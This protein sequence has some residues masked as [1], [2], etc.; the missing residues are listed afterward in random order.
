[1]LEKLCSTIIDDR[2]SIN[3]ASF[4]LVGKLG[5]ST[6][7]HPKPYNSGQA[8]VIGFYFRKVYGLSDVLYGTNR[9]N[10][11]RFRFSFEHMGH[12]VVLKSLSPRE[13]C[14]AYMGSHNQEGKNE[15][16][17][18]GE[19]VH[20]ERPIMVLVDR[21]ERIER[22]K[23]L[24]GRKDLRRGVKP[25][26]AER[27]SLLLPLLLWPLELVVSSASK[28]ESS[29]G[30]VSTSSEAECLSDDS[31]YD[32]DLLVVRRLMNSQIGEDTETQRENI[33]HSRC[34]ILGNLCSTIINGG[35]YMKKLAL[36]TIVHLR[37]YRLQWI[38]EKRELLLDKQVKVMFTLGGYQDRVVCDVVPM[39]ATHLLLGRPC[40]FDKKV[41][42]D[43]VTNRFTFIHLGKR[44]V[45]KPL[46]PRKVHEDQKKM[47]VKKENKRKTKS[48]MKKR[49]SKSDVE[50][51]K[52]RGKE[53]VEEKS[54]S[55]SRKE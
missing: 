22:R 6:P 31:H 16:C 53:K 15:R 18:L 44:V 14:D 42:H 24:K 19:G 35:N 21:R 23:G 55:V 40:Q 34:L 10:T 3:M 28:S 26:V 25:L 46:S 9:G 17:K 8:S 27:S 54:K 38:S 39:E 41:I 20:L 33:F 29:I 4:G 51:R 49:V 52:E 30:E 45:L 36:P 2:S 5:I 37:L 12:K 50:K 32:G 47:K 1:M 43:G 48:K 11:H 7:L 13:V